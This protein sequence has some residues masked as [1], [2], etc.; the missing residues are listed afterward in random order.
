[1]LMIRNKLFNTN[2]LHDFDRMAEAYEALTQVELHR[3]NF[4]EAKDLAQKTLK[5]QDHR[6]AHRLAGNNNL[7][8]MESYNLMTQVAMH[9]NDF[10][11]ALK[12]S[13]EALKLYS[14]VLKEP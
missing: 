11:N 10:D 4:K 12:Y 1:A 9:E 13:D 8:R 5:Y 14:D 2:S 3:G 7:D 6:W